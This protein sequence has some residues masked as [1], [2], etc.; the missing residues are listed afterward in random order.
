MDRYIKTLF[1]L[2]LNKIYV[3]FHLLIVISVI[4]NM[5]TLMHD[6]LFLIH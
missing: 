1:V 4:Y 6:R 2:Y 5:F 3:E